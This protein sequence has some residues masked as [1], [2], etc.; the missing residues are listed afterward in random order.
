MKKTLLAII[1]SGIAISSL[2]ADKAAAGFYADQSLQASSIP[3]GV[4]SVTRLYYRLPLSKSGGILWESTKIDMGLIN[5]LS[6]AYD[7]AGVFVDIEPI[8]FFD[9][10]LTAQFTG[11][12]DALGFGY[13]N[14]LGFGAAFDNASLEPLSQRN[15]SGYLLSAA[16]TLKAAFGRF[17]ALN[18]FTITYF[19]AGAGS[20]YFFER[21]ANCVLAENDYELANQAYA[22][23][24]IVPGLFT[25]LSDSVLIVPGSG[26]LSHSM[27]GVCVVKSKLGEKHSFYAAL[28]LGTYLADRYYQYS[29]YAGGQ[30]GVALAL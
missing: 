24:T 13:V 30:V 10:S 8:A 29:F 12:F 28:M 19:H 18:T 15:A 6:P 23:V 5:Q 27:A 1:L 20:G 9:L 3:L 22:L 17:A 7:L 26:Y 25:G 4:Q 11:Y 14:V 2:F 21:I 16:P